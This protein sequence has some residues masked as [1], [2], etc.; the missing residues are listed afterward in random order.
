MSKPLPPGSTLGILGGGQLGRMLAQSAASMGYRVHI[1]TNETDS[2]AAQVAAQTTRADW[3]DEAALTAF[4]RDCDVVTYEF[5]NIPAAAA[6]TVER[7]GISVW[8]SPH[9]LR[10]CQHRI[11]EKTALR[12]LGIPVASFAAITSSADL[13][14]A[15]QSVGFPAIVKTAESGYDGKGQAKVTGPESLAA[16]FAHFGNVACILESVVDFTMELSVLVA[17]DAHGTA[18]C[19]DAVQNIH[20]DHILHET[21]APAPISRETAIEAERLALTLAEGLEL[22]GLIA[23]ELFLTKDGALLVNELAPR[24]HNSGHW[25]M[26][27][28]QHSQFAQ[29]ARA[30]L[31]LPLGAS[32]RHS[33]ATMRNLIGAEAEDWLDYLNDPLAH[34]HLYGKSEARPGRKMGHVTWLRPRTDD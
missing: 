19:F 14:M 30:V 18:A 22:R 11:R 12:N 10:T 26:E 5:E 21:I 32:A 3:S 27:A 2:A 6:E 33:D 31:G 23:V 25:T 13:S 9:I 24:P 15:A 1:F 17:R 34:L 29:A 16:A 20:R 4:A 28:C 8:P 7:A